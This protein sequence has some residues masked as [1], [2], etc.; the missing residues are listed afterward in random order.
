M[1]WLWL[2]L[3]GL[4]NG[5]YAVMVGSGGGYIMVPVLLI[6]FDIEPQVAAGTSLA[7]IAVTTLSGSMV[8]RRMGF[9]DRRSGYLFAAA[10]IPG[11]ILAPL[12]LKSVTSGTFTFLFGLLLI[13]I[14]AFVLLRPHP[15]KLP[16]PSP[17]KVQ[18]PVS[19]LARSR[20]IRAKGGQ[21]FEYTVNEPLATSFN[22]FLG[23]VSSFFGTGGGFMRIPVLVTV[24]GFPVRV[25]VATSIFALSFYAT[26]GAAT[27]A[28]LGHVD[29]YP[30]FV[31]AG[32]GMLIGGQIGAKLAQKVRGV[33]VLRIMVTV[34]L[35][36]GV[37][38][39]ILSIQG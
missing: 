14:A 35:V 27:H 31:M 26:A 30:T 2:I 10:A 23:F 33:W 19:S 21:V 38:L 9:I 5:A 8:Y 37:R 29:W 3:L 7:L 12:A 36:L 24:F 22:F 25:A 11:S 6:F 15:S 16:S 20:R 32:I 4:G 1:E 13:G 39:I 34:L 17:E 28:A 18:R